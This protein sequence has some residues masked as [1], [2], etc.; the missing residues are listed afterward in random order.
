M[1]DGI[2]IGV[3]IGGTKIAFA[4]VN[5]AGDVVA[6]HRL[7][8]LVSQGAEVVFQQIAQGIQ[9]MTSRVAAPIDGIGIG[10]PGHL[11]PHTGLV[12]KATN[13]HWDHLNVLDGIRAQLGDDMPLYLQKDGNAAA[14]GEMRFGAGRGYNDFVLITIGTGLGGGAFANGELVLGANYSGMEIGHMPLDRN[15]RMCLCG[16]RGCPEMYVSGVGL[17][18]GAQMYLPQYPQSS[19]NALDEITTAAILDAF[20]QNDE[21]AQRLIDEMTDW[22]CA[23]MIACMGILNPGV[24][25]IG[26][27]LGHALFAVLSTDVKRKLRSRTRREIHIEVPI[28]ESQVAD[29]AIG[30]A[31]LVWYAQER[32]AKN[33]NTN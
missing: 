32:A 1:S 15:G 12:Y 27:G 11:N 30:A 26:G 2:A 6:S 9:H 24:F 8:T 29:S 23:V 5:R 13:M 28:A 33:D 10:C 19:L 25:V 22:L 20:E 21:L 31:C 14:L 18:V 16:M 4:A 17:L 7:A 3:D